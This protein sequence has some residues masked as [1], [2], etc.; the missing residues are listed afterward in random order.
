[1]KTDILL[2]GQ[3]AELV[4]SKQMTLEGVSDT[5]KL[6]EAMHKQYPALAVSKYVVA[7]NQQVITKNT[8]LSNNSIVALLPP[9]SGG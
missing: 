4:G 1:M 9:F 5:D 6:I 8:Q 2:F 3:L 7:V